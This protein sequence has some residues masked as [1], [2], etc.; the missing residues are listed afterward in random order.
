MYKWM[1]LE[2]WDPTPIFKSDCLDFFASEMYELF[3]YL[4]H[5]W[6][7]NVSPPFCRL[8]LHF[9]DSLLCCAKHFQF[10]IV[11]LFIFALVTLVF[12]VKSKKSLPRSTSRSLPSMFS[13]QSF[14]VSGLLIKSKLILSWF[15]YMVQDR[16]LCCCSVPKSRLILGNPMDCRTS[17]FPVRYH[18]LEFAQTHVHWVMDAT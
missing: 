6:F 3:T 18:L 15:L 2:L 11:S 12:L 8:P 5:I 17:G 16:D 7:A 14:M 10:Y 13:S 4:R 9:V 1:K